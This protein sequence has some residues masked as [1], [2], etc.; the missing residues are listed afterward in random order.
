[1]NYQQLDKIADLCN[2]ILIVTLILLSFASLKNHAWS[3]LLRSGLAV[4]S[5]QQLSKYAQKKQIWGDDFPSTHFAVALAL[6]VA[7]VVLRRRF[8]PLAL[9][10]LSGYGA[11]ML[12]IHHIKP[13][14]YHT[15]VEML[16][17]FFAVP[18]ALV[19]HW[20]KR[21]ARPVAN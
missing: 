19:F 16:G 9:I 15:P 2:P 8:W 14:E 3:F 13:S 17:S 11:L 18:L 4:V 1:M 5:V 6:C 12:Y 20:R 21:K 10:Y 7:L